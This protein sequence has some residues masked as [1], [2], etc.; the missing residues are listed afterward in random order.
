MTAPRQFQRALQLG[1]FA[2]A[3]DELRQP[4]PLCQLEMAAQRPDANHLVDAE[5][6]AYPFDFPR[7]QIAQFEVALDQTARLLT[8]HDATR[9]GDRLHPRRE[10]RHMTNW[11][12]LSVPA[13]VDHAQNHFASVDTD[14]R[15]RGWLTLRRKPLPMLPQCLLQPQRRIECALGMVLMRDR[16][17]EQR[18]DAV[19]GGLHHVTVVAMSGVDHKFQRR[20]DNRARVLR[21]KVAHHCGRIF[22]VR[23]QRRHRLALAFE[24]SAGRLLRRDANLGSR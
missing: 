19:T 1:H 13:G 21:V 5:R 7:A 9:R 6:L 8:D 22:D 10:V 12:V 15:L 14:T 20:I 3:P 18:E 24:R 11:G 23:E 4:T 17:A 16:R 2:L